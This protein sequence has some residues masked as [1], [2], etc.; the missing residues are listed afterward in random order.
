MGIT[1]PALAGLFD[2]TC[3]DLPQLIADKFFKFLQLKIASEVDTFLVEVPVNAIR[4]DEIPLHVSR[5]S[6]VNTLLLLPTVQ[7][8]GFEPATNRLEGGCSI[9]LS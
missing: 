2:S 9:R 5:T 4:K 7:H 6:K 1:K 3:N 8:A